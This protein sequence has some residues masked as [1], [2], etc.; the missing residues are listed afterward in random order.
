MIFSY[1][2]IHGSEN[3]FMRFGDFY[4]FI[5]NNQ[6]QIRKQPVGVFP[7]FVAE[8]SIGNRKH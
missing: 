6:K 1:Y 2:S 3:L 5:L 8:R 4:S 7:Y